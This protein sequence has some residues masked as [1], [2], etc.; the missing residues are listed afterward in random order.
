[1]HGPSQPNQ[2]FGVV[3]LQGLVD[4][5]AAL[6]C[7]LQIEHGAYAAQSNSDIIHESAY[8]RP[9]AALD[10]YAEFRQIYLHNVEAVNGNGACWNFRNRLSAHRQF[11]QTF[12]AD[13]YGRIYRGFLQ[14]SPYESGANFS[15]T[16][17]SHVIPGAAFDKTPRQIVCIVFLAQT[18][19]RFIFLRQE[20]MPNK[21]Q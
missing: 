8:I 7:S 18:P 4:A 12:A 1:M 17:G 15:Q 16:F 2:V 20:A 19:S 9:A 11:V 3:E 6:L 14:N 5:E 10:A 13:A 21:N